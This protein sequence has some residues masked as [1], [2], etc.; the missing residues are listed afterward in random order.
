[1][2]LWRLWLDVF[3]IVSNPRGTGL[4][5]GH[6]IPLRKRRCAQD[7]RLSLWRLWLDV[8]RIVSNP[9]GTGLK[10][11][12]YIPL[13]KRRCAQDDRL[14]LWRLWLDV[15]RIV[16]NPASN[17][18]GTGLKTGHYKPWRG[19]EVK[20]GRY[21]IGWCGTVSWDEALGDGK[22]AAK[23]EGA[24]GDFQAGSGLLAFVFVAI[25]AAAAMLRTS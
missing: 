13:R 4:K 10:T 16:S 3:R 11:G 8:F 5:T 19:T 20:V 25:D 17:P 22:R 9:R 23:A 6:Y 2:S 14:F 21:Y 15:F 7:D 18:R 1:M 12:H 24:R